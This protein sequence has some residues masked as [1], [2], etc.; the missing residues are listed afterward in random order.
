MKKLIV[1]AL[2]CSLLL[3]AGC[4]NNLVEPKHKSS[5]ADYA[6][7]QSPHKQSHKKVEKEKPKN[8]D[9]KKEKSE[10]TDQKKDEDIK[11]DD[12]LDSLQNKEEQS[13]SESQSSSSSST[14]TPIQRSEHKASS[15]LPKS[16]S[17]TS[18]HTVPRRNYT[19]YNPQPN[20]YFDNSWTTNSNANATTQ[21]SATS[22]SN[23]E[24][25]NTSSSSTASLYIVI[26]PCSAA[27]SS[28]TIPFGSC[29]M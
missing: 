8:K 9:D 14:P 7:I 11:M 17:G 16:N 15:S 25:S 23:S 18:F 29:F 22:S 13:S 12:Q 2:S 28:P 20:Y 19:Y 24:N 3:L 27:Y 5:A 10:K 4:R 6:I 21:S 26:L 1:G